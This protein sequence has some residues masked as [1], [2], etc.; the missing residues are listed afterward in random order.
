M[1]SKGFVYL[2]GAIIVVNMGSSTKLHS[3]GTSL[4]AIGLLLLVLAVAELIASR[5]NKND[6]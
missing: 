5:I 2:G 3:D 6:K 1:E 4:M